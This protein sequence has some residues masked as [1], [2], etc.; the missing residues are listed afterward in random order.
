MLEPFTVIIPAHNEEAVIARCL[1]A[2][3]SGAPVGAQIEIIVAANGCTDDTVEVAREADGD[4]IVLDLAQCSKTR[5]INAANAAA[6]HF[7]RI[8]L[9][10]DVVC[11]Y[12]SLAALAEAL[13]EPGVMVAAPGIRHDFSDANWVVRAYYG[14]WSKQPYARSGRGGAGCYGLSRAALERIGSFPEIIGD[15]IWIHTRFAEDER[16]FVTRTGDGQPVFSLVRPPDTGLDQV[17][18]E[19]RRMFG[20][21]EVRRLYPSPHVTQL[22]KGGGFAGAI[23]SDASALEVIVFTIIKGLVRLD[24]I[25]RKWLGAQKVWVRDTSSRQRS[26]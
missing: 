22:A 10:A 26:A 23:R 18:V 1:Q 9:D 15:D 3:R 19:A 17:R 6:S 13:R 21:A 11:G 12:A 14:A 5:A 8:Y 20:N 4:A 7:P 16:R 2:A 24:M 25:R